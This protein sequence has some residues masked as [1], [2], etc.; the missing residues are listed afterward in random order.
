M[1]NRILNKI[2]KEIF[3][4]ISIKLTYLYSA[5]TESSK[6]IPLFRRISS[7]LGAIDRSIKLFAICSHTVKC[8]SSF[9][10]SLCTF[11]MVLEYDVNTCC[12]IENGCDACVVK[13]SCIT[14]RTICPFVCICVYLHSRFCNF[15]LA[16]MFDTSLLYSWLFFYDNWVF[17]P[18]EISR[19]YPR[20]R[21]CYIRDPSI[22][23]VNLKFEGG[24]SPN[25]GVPARYF[26]LRKHFIG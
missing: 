7:L 9:F 1:I 22:W 8:V 14:W 11:A 16:I 2:S 19:I 13:L 5:R 18:T 21:K 17:V 12:N 4:R 20:S 26:R 10:I 23:G 24:K 6:T 25:P 15:S 3:H